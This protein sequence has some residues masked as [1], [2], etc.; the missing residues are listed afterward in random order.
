[1]SA[2]RNTEIWSTRLQRE[3]L[4]LTT[5]NAS[6]EA[7][8]EVTGVLPPFVTVKDHQLD[9]TKGD[10]AVSFLPGSHFVRN[11]EERNRDNVALQEGGKK[12]ILTGSGAVGMNTRKRNDGVFSESN[13]VF[14]SPRRK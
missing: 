12:N 6:E 4:A 13:A 7:K 1:M 9:I 3:L 8:D 14:V 11:V 5:D 2:D 10:C